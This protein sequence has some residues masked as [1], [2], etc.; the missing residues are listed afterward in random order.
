MVPSPK[1]NSKRKSLLSKEQYKAKSTREQ[2]T[3]ARQANKKFIERTSGKDG[4]WQTAYSSEIYWRTT[5]IGA[6]R[7]RQI[8]YGVDIEETS[9]FFAE[10]LYTTDQYEQKTKEWQQAAQENS[11]TH[12]AQL[13]A[14]EKF[15]GEPATTYRHAV[16]NSD[17]GGRKL[18]ICANDIEL[19]SQ[20]EALYQYL[21][22][23]DDILGAFITYHENDDPYC[24][25]LHNH[26]HILWAQAKFDG[27]TLTRPNEHPFVKKLADFMDEYNDGYVSSICVNNPKYMFYYMNMD[28][29]IFLGS[30]GRLLFNPM[31]IFKPNMEWIRK[32]KGERAAIMA[33]NQRPKNEILAKRQHAI[34]QMSWIQEQCY[35]T[36]QAECS[37]ILDMVQDVKEWLADQELRGDLNGRWKKAIDKTYYRLR[38]KGKQ[39]S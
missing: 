38:Q 1:K 8:L 29:R 14:D 20:E 37:Q 6:P 25:H 17:H 9:E 2:R 31:D 10:Q 28:P 3:L 39:R 12:I 7:L 11:Q 15:L 36:E 33:L 30:F 16:E 32:K 5:V 24:T 22:Q 4:K 19:T 18:E 34:E 26:Y 23:N 13:V 27:R 35:S 21:K